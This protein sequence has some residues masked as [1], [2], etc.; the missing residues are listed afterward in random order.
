MIVRINTIHI[1]LLL[2][3]CAL[4][5]QTA[6]TEALAWPPSPDPARILYTRSISGDRDIE[7]ERSFLGKV[8]DFIVGAEQQRRMLVQPLAVA[9]DVTGNL[10]VS[11][12]GARCVHVFDFADEK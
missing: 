11:D 1:A 2:L 10:Y 12:P 8:W 4:H 6:A 3:P 7:G 5:A 9:V